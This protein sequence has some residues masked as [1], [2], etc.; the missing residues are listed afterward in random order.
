MVTF[1]FYSNVARSQ[2][3]Q[4]LSRQNARVPLP[5]H[6]KKRKASPFSSF[7]PIGGCLIIN[8]SISLFPL[9]NSTIIT[10]VLTRF[11]SW[12]GI[13]NALLWAIFLPPPS[14]L[15]PSATGESTWDPE[16]FVI[17]IIIFPFWWLSFNKHSISLVSVCFA[18]FMWQVRAQPKD[19]TWR[20]WSQA[21]SQAGFEMWFPTL[22]HKTPRWV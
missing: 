18:L 20:T 22:R 2:R 6:T 16:V 19:L 21:E 8:F 4:N 11:E 1:F 9:D 3:S 7:S 13:W 12:Y 17:R 15:F 10:I 5:W 14:F